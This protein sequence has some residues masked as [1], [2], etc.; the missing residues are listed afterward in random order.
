MAP[1][2]VEGDWPNNTRGQLKEHETER[3][4]VR[5]IPKLRFVSNFVSEEQF[6]INILT[7]IRLDVRL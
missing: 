5:V 1:R 7:N 6:K 2:G 4:L 3:W